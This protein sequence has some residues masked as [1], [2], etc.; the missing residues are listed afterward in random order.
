MNQ[1][2]QFDTDIFLTING[3]HT[4]LMD[5]FMYTFSSTFVWSMVYL[6]TILALIRA[7]GWRIC[8]PAV[9]CT[10]IAITLADQ[11][12]ATLIRPYI[13]RL[14]PA[15]PDNPISH[16]VHIVN[17]YRGGSYGFPSCH[18]ANTFAFATIITLIVKKRLLSITLFIWAIVNCWSRIYLG[19]HYPGDLLVGAAIGSFYAIMMYYIFNIILDKSAFFGTLIE[20]NWLNR[21]LRLE[22]EHIIMGVFI[23]TTLAIFIYSLIVTLLY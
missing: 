13:Q 20:H 9:I 16:L 8:M 21:L 5:V 12:C 17:G 14:R 2:I 3:W 6:I 1:I 18:A 23:L 15:N 11:T 19:V 10:V 4:P 7:F 22:G